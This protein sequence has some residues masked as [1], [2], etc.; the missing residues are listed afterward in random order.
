MKVTLDI[1]E[2]YYLLE[3]CLRGSHLRSG[4]ILRFVD[5]WYELFTK[6]ERGKLYYDT[7]RLI[8]N[9]KFEACS[10]CCGA[11][12][13]FM[14][15]YNPDNQYRVTVSDGSQTKTVDAYL[16]DGRYYI[17]SQRFCAPEFITKIE[18]I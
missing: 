5:D 1:F 4:T 15:R 18:K 13:V 10:A 7:L 9:N 3:S 16:L 14:A 2:M 17:K 11:D 6:E 8:Y 12:I